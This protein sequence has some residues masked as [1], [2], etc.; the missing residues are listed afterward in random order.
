MPR[1]TA[2]A[3]F[4]AGSHDQGAHEHEQQVPGRRDRHRSCMK[5]PGRGNGA[6]MNH[7]LYE[8][9]NMDEAFNAMATAG[10]GGYRPPGASPE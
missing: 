10:A 3:A 4:E 7:Y 5:K 2:E 9:S 6:G 8:V 1:P